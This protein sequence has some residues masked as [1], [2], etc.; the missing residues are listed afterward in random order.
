MRFFKR[1]ILHGK[2]CKFLEDLKKH[3]FASKDEMYDCIF[4]LLEEAERLEDPCFNLIQRLI[5]II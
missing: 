4:M 3:R 1:A 5:T 2:L